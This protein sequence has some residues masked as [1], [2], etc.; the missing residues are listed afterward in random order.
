MVT[1]KANRKIP[2][3]ISK[4]TKFFTYYIVFINNSNDSRYTPT[5]F[6]KEQKE[7]KEK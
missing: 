3:Q 2:T 4:S 7:K 5:F 6:K 1:I